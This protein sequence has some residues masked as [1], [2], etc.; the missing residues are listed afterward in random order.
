MKKL[1]IIVLAAFLLS[2]FVVNA[3]EEKKDT[4]KGYKFT[5]E[6][7]LNLFIREPHKKMDYSWDRYKGCRCN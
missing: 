6:K 5:L 7:E 3:Q 2:T 4:I 1:Q